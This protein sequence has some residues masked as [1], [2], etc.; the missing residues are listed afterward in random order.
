MPRVKKTTSAVKVQSKQSSSRKPHQQNQGV[1]LHRSFYDSL[2]QLNQYWQKQTKDTQKELEKSKSQL[3]KAQDA[4]K[5]A[6]TNK[7]AQKKVSSSAKQKAQI[8]KSQQ[9][10]IKQQDIVNAAKLAMEA[11]K[12]SHDFAKLQAKKYAELNKMIAGFEKN[13]QVEAKPA[14]TALPKATKNNK[15]LKAKSKADTAEDIEA[16]TTK[17]KSVKSAKAAKSKTA[18]VAKSK[19]TTTAAAN[20]IA[21]AV[22]K[23]RGRKAKP[24]TAQEEK[25]DKQ[26]LSVDDIFETQPDFDVFAQDEINAVEENQAGMVELFDENVD[27]LYGEDLA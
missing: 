8:A 26:L 4:V 15:Q 22:S 16:V 27:E 25:T 9:Q 18:P 12:Q 5:K 19:K 20:P 23:K 24:V 21:D 6:K 2:S 7:A 3:K 1:Q 10:L 17:T 11:I 14:S 13:Y